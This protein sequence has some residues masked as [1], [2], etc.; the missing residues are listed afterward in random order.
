M[1]AITL[2]TWLFNDEELLQIKR[3]IMAGTLNQRLQPCEVDAIA[4]IQSELDF[5]DSPE[6]IAISNSYSLLKEEL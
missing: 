4:D 1:R 2:P 6:Y 5:R 3:R